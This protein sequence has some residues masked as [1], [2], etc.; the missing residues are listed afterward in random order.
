MQSRDTGVIKTGQS[1]WRLFSFPLLPARFVG[2]QLTCAEF[3]C[4]E[5][6]VTTPEASN[7]QPKRTEGSQSKSPQVSWEA[8]LTP[9]KPSD[10]TTDLTD[11]S[12]VAFKETLRQRPLAKLHPDS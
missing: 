12:T 7:K 4:G 5:A 8:D 6:H 2:R 9:Q 3:P 10:E 1:P 11:T